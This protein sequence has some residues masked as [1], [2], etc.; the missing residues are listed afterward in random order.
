MTLTTGAFNRASGRNSEL[1]ALGYSLRQRSAVQPTCTLIID[2]DG[3]LRMNFPVGG[4]LAD[5]I[6][7]EILKAASTTNQSSLSKPES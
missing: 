5:A 7:A 4:N 1:P 6:V 2:P 3:R